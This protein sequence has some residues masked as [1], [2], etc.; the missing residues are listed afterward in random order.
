MDGHYNFQYN[1]AK[2]GLRHLP[3]T[4]HTHSYIYGMQTHTLHAHSE[5]IHG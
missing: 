1:K 2:G 3:S 4:V 5:Y